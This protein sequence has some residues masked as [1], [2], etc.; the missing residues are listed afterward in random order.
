M[1]IT[2]RRDVSL[3]PLALS[4]AAAMFCWVSDPE[5]SQNIGLRSEPTLE[6]T[7]AWISNA[8]NDASIKPFAI[9]LGRQ[10]AGIVVL[11]RID[12]HLSTARFSIYIGERAAR[13]AGIGASAAYLACAEGFR[14]LPLNKIGLVVHV[15]NKTAIT[16]YARLGFKLEGTLRDEFKLNGRLIDAHYMGLLRRDFEG[17]AV[18][19]V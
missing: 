5:I 7:Q 11:D 4:H 12:A 16:C 6:K 2:L 1:T 17:C 18:T 19:P 10:H 15:E 3:Q 8:L 14:A 13:G 9:Y